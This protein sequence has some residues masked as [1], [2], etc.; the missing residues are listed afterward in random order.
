LPITISIPAP[1]GFV[2]PGI[3]TNFQS[4]FVG[5]LPAD[6]HWNLKIS[7]DPEG[8]FVVLSDQV[9]ANLSRDLFGYHWLSSQTFLNVPLAQPVNQTDVHI[10]AELET[11]TGVIDSGTKTVKWDPVTGVPWQL[12]ERTNALASGGFTAADRAQLQTTE[13]RTQVLGIPSDLVLEGPSG[14][15]PTSLAKL[16]SRRTLDRMTLSEATAG[17]TCQPVRFTVGIWF[18]GI[19]VRV[20]TIPPELVPKTPD[21]EWYFPDLAV[22]RI[23]RGADCEYRRGIH[24]PTFMQERPWQW[25]MPFLQD[26]AL[27]AP[28]P[29]TTIA[30]DWRDGVCG[31]VF[32]QNLP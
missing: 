29:D 16:F 13:L 9:D 30:V 17:P 1:G 6:T 27:G 31:Q 12:W 5:P 32:V 11:S 4:D 24:T 21:H 2:G 19:I 20:T 15:I 23:F 26:N 3:Y 25:G 18:F 28:P 7:T 22:L 8:N 14:P 10:L